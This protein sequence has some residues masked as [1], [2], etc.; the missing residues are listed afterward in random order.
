[1][2]DDLTADNGNYGGSSSG[3]GAIVAVPARH[4]T[5]P[6]TQVSYGPPAIPEIINAKPGPI[7]LLHALRRRW[8]IAAGLGL[9]TG[10]LLAA[11]V[12]FF[13]PVRYEVVAMLRI[14]SSRPNLLG[15]AG[16]PDA[17]FA[18]YKRTQAALLK[19]NFVLQDTLRKPEVQRLSLVREH[20]D[21]VL[22]WLSGQ[23]SVDYPGD[24]EIM[25]ISMRGDRPKELATIVNSVK[26]SYM[27]EI[28]NAEREERLRQR[29]VLER[30]YKKNRE[31]IRNRMDQLYRLHEE[32]N[33]NS[34]ASA[35]L[36][37][38]MATRDLDMAIAARNSI[39]N[40]I[41]QIE[42][43]MLLLKAQAEKAKDLELPD[44]VIDQQIA[45]DPEVAELKQQLKQINRAIAEERRRVR[46]ADAPS[47]VRLQQEIQAI[48][49]RLDE[50]RSELRPI[51]LETFA[52]STT[53]GDNI[54]QYLPMLEVERDAL[55]GKLDSATQ[56]AQQKLE[57]LQK[58]EK[59]S[60]EIETRTMELAELQEI[61]RKMGAELKSMAVEVDARPRIVSI[62]D[63]SVPS[64]NDAVRKYVGIAFA[65]VA[66]LAGVLF[67]VALMEF[68]SRRLNSE[69][70]VRDGLGLRVIGH[71]PSL[72]GRAWRK[73][74]DPT[75]S[76]GAHLQSLLTDSV[77]SIRAT[78]IHS[79]GSNP[80]RVVMVS[81]SENQEGKTTVASQL[82]A[83]L[84]RAGRRTL[85]IDGDLRNPTGHFV[86]GLPLEPGFAE[87]LRGDAER[88]AAIHA[89]PAPNLWMMPAGQYDAS[90]AQAISGESL[91][92]LIK[93]LK[94]QY[95]FIVVDAPPVLKVAD[96]LIFG[97]CV[98]AA[99]LSVR[100]DFSR[101]PNIYEASER[102]RAVGV[103]VLG[104]IVNGVNDKP[105]KR[106]APIHV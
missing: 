8:M 38:T 88:E 83:S 100:R 29:D 106:S 94:D 82:A 36:K 68:Q 24:A 39:D 74:G 80:P 71:L 56:V 69:R 7:E 2:S 52:L 50:R 89:T 59:N 30:L 67:G 63:A 45:S 73:L 91:V 25:R 77:D 76:A 99:V 95:E 54:K 18:T 23:L 57:E 101:I 70:E 31:E 48:E 58:M 96:P 78:L 84:A 12:W 4:T 65:G 35:Q 62:E 37:R 32:Y 98:D 72:S 15:G 92:S 75:S 102:L 47:L 93:S 85:M 49:E 9:L 87:V 81:S 79:N 44:F 11:M 66:G 40:Q 42:L 104:A 20:K 51:L 61:T 86:F 5:L 64:G 41:E 33:T 55:A 13:V 14:A 46:R 10:G 1:M 97:Q 53:Q 19:S 27:D 16:T 43:K 22:D 34:S 26:E 90:M 105:M 103:K 21:D 3:S 6:A 60:V 17:D 28:V